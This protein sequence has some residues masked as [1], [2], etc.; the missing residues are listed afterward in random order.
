ME[1]SLWDDVACGVIPVG[2]RLPE[3]HIIFKKIEDEQIEAEVA[4]LHARLNKQ[5]GEKQMMEAVPTPAVLTSAFYMS[6]QSPKVLK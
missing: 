1:E 5:K 3:P 2:Q 6:K 4:A